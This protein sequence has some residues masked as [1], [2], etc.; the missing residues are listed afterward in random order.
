MQTYPHDVV[1]RLI[2]LIY[3]AALTPDKWTDF[4]EELGNVVDGHVLNLSSL[5]PSQGGISFGCLAEAKTDPAF[6]A[7]YKAYYWKVDPWIE[8]ARHRRMLRPGLLGLGEN[9]VLPSL[10]KKTEFY[11]DLGRQFE[12]IGG[13]SAVIEIEQSLVALSFTQRE[14]GQFGEA[15]LSLI[16]VLAPHLE[17]A[18]N[19]QLRLQ[20]AQAVASDASFAL[21][22]VSLGIFFV[23]ETGTLLFANRAGQEI[24]R[25]HDGLTVRRGELY[26]STPAQTNSLR[27]AIKAA[28]QAGSR[29]VLS[30]QPM[31]TLHRPSGRRP[32]SILV[33]SLPTHKLQLGQEAASAAIFVTDPDRAPV[34]SAEVIRLMLRL[35]PAEAQLVHCLVIGHSLK[36]AAEHLSIGVETARKRLK[37]IFQKTD[38]HRQSDL[39]RLALRCVVPEGISGLTDPARSH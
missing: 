32:L 14:F 1:V 18:L 19:V 37:V 11:N 23:S 20:G 8:A 13:I 33:A 35:T 24:L 31:K 26:A 27:E 16:R 29:P 2:G 12:I 5:S 3:D 38:T 10:L 39:V 4:L 25:A 28:I 7:D 30:G 17:R 9:T 36:E 34:T 15:E 22:H 6:V 21:D